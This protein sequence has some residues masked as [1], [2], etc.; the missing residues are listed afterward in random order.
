LIESRRAGPAGAPFMPRSVVVA[1]LRTM[2]FGAILCVALLSPSVA[3]A[4]G[5]PAAAG[6]LS[7]ADMREMVSS[8]EV[9]APVAAIRA[10]RQAAPKADVVR[11]NLC[12]RGEA[13]VYVIM[14]L[15]R[16]GRFVRVKIDAASGK[17]A[18]VH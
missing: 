3:G 15:G 12:R 9:I 6:C 1:Q 4:D 8:K 7:P 5:A 14:A 13:L 17:V 11:A 2:R 18:S 10:A 16:D